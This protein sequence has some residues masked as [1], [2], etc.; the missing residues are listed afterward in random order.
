MGKNPSRARRKAERLEVVIPTRLVRADFD[1]VCK[2]AEEFGVKPATW[3]RI[4]ILRSLATAGGKR[5]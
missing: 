5:I 3:V 1:K 2:L 4:Q